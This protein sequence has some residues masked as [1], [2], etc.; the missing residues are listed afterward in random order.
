MSDLGKTS[1]TFMKRSE[2]LRERFLEL[3]PAGHVANDHHAY[4][5]K[6]IV[7]SLLDAWSDFNRSV[8]LKSAV[9]KCT[10]VGGSILPKGKYVAEAEALIAAKTS[11]KGK[12]GVEPRWHDARESVATAKKLSLGNYLTY[13]AAISS[14]SSPADQIRLVRN[15]FA[16]ERSD[17]AEKLMASAGF[18]SGMDLSP[19]GVTGFVISDSRMVFEFWVDELQ[20][21]AAASVY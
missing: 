9:G 5:L 13:S 17:C 3:C 10:T 4:A 15:F 12:I 14:L 18:V 21:I 6:F 8:V 7:I 20:L 16:H 2:K 1:R 11:R 19:T